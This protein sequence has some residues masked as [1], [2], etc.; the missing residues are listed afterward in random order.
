ME[1]DQQASSIGRP[2]NATS[3]AWIDIEHGEM[4]LLVGK[5][6]MKFN[7]HQSIQLI[8]EEKN[9]CIQIESSFI[10]FEEQ[11][12]KIFQE[13]ILEGYQLK[14]NSFPTKKLD[15]ELLSPIPKL[16]DLILMSD[17]DEEGALAMMN[18]GQSKALRL[19]Q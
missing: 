18:E 6:K 7:L 19:P 14:T 5:E 3:Q 10:P 17:E 15:F 11:A 4:T 1:D 13:D 8:D 9:C 16:E 2:P 12:P